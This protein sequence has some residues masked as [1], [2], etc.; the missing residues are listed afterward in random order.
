V[1]QLDAGAFGLAFVAP[2]GCD[3]I[4]TLPSIREVAGILMPKKSYKL[5]IALA[6]VAVAAVALSVWLGRPKP[7]EV[8]VATV[9]RGLVRNT[10]SKTRAGTIQA[11]RRAGIS[12]ATGGQIASLLVK[13]GDHVEAGQVL[14]ELWNDDRRAQLAQASSE[15]TAARANANQACIRADVARRE[16]ERQRSLKKKN[17]TSAEAVDKADGEARAQAAACTAARAQV[18]VS[19]AR[20]QAAQAE[21]DKTRLVAPFSGTVAE[22]NG[23]VG[24]FVTPSPVGIPTP[25]TIDLVDT[26]CLYVSAPIDEVDAPRVRVGMP[27]RISLDAMAGKVFDSRVRRIAPYILE[28]EKQ[29]RTVDVEADFNC[30]AQ[31][32]DLL[33]GYSADIE[34]VL[35]KKDDA[36]RIPTQAILEGNQVL[37]LPADGVLQERHI[38]TGL[39]NWNWTEV[40]GGLEAGQQIVRSVEREGV[41]AS[42]HAVPEPAATDD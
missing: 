13:K 22:I 39:G 20:E 21:L 33:P 35:E 29:A 25:P 26:S 40:T 37:V 1:S 38:T 2:P 6:L 4:E 30:P 41:A 10:V 9:A 7:V 28:V 36:L 23:E 24:E 19:A 8:R 34:I 17:L 5:I 27:V 32:A 3:I 14:V 11:C 12:P 16:A 15:A 42:A 31:C 18:D